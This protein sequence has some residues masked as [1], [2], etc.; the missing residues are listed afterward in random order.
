MAYIPDAAFDLAVG[1]VITHGT[2]LALCSTE[3]TSFAQVATYRLAEKTGITPGAASNAT[4]SGRQT[5]IPAT[6][7][8]GTGDGDAAFWA[9][10]DG[11]VLAAT[12][13]LET[14]LAITTGISYDV[15]S[16]AVGVRDAEVDA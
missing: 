3:P 12:G 16:F 7:V 5:V 4:P 2:N 11:S 10:Y 15:A 14:P 13:P 1:Y 9:L 6:T 8:V